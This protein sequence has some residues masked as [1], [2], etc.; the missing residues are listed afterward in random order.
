MV[1]IVDIVNI[2]VCED[3]PTRG[4]QIFALKSFPPCQCKEMM[5]FFC[6]IAYVIIVLFAGLEGIY[7]I[8]LSNRCILL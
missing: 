3:F 8:T 5:Y 4:M 7:F 2:V 1:Y 6:A